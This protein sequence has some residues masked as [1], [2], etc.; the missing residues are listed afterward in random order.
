MGAALRAPKKAPTCSKNERTEGGISLA[1]ADRDKLRPKGRRLTWRKE[2]TFEAMSLR[3]FLV[4]SAYPKSLIKG[5]VL[6]IPPGRKKKM[7]QLSSS[8]FASS[9]LSLDST[10]GIGRTSH[11]SIVPEEG[12]RWRGRH[13]RKEKGEKNGV[14]LRL[15]VRP[16]PSSFLVP[17]SLIHQ[18]SP[19]KQNT[20]VGDEGEQVL[21]QQEEQVSINE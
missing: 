18:G 13:K 3:S 2:T 5:T 6:T 20:K 11:S 14:S 4:L 8:P 10:G 16:C 21:R 15:N 19:E 1:K 17:S 9:A 7:S 12:R